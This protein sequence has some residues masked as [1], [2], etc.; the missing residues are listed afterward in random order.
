MAAWYLR[1]LDGAA[2]VRRLVTI[3]TPHHGTM[4]ARFGKGRALD[5]LRPDSDIVSRLREQLPWTGPRL[6]C[7]WSEAD[8]FVVPS[9]N[10][11]V[12]GVTNVE[13]EGLGH[14]QL[15]LWPAGWRAAFDALS[16]G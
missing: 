7:L 3:G 13:L 4:A 9:A 10:A 12:S 5:E 11:Q 8:P 16:I 14:C 1:R 2:Q 15:L 6:V